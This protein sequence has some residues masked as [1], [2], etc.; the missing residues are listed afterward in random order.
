VCFWIATLF[1][2]L[3][4]MLIKTVL[5]TVHRDQNGRAAQLNPIF[6]K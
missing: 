1:Y 6:G 4:E 3:V 5:K 2:C